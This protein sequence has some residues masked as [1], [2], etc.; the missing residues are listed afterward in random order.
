MDKAIA[1]FRKLVESLSS[2]DLHSANEATTRKLVIDEVLE[3][4]LR[5]D[6]KADVTYEERVEEDVKTTY[7]DYILR[8]A[9][10]AIVVDAKR[11]GVAFDLSSN[12]RTCLFDGAISKS[13]AGEATRQAR[14]YARRKAIPFAVATTGAKT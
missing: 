5:W 1:K 14:D 4:V 11:G 7:A 13:A 8:T 2:H 10:T 3:K 6:K 12:R 9:A